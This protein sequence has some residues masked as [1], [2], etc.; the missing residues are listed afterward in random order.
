MGVVLVTFG[1]RQGNFWVKHVNATCVVTKNAKTP[2]SFTM[3]YTT[4]PV[5]FVPNVICTCAVT[6]WY[7]HAFTHTYIHTYTCTYNRYVCVCTYTC[8]YVYMHKYRHVCD[9]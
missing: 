5:V 6:H 1:S 4:L 9:F 8:L 7:V 3:H 2:L